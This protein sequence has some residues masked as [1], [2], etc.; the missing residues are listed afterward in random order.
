MESISPQNILGVFTLVKGVY[1]LYPI[2]G[3]RRIQSCTTSPHNK[4]SRK[5]TPF[6]PQTIFQT[7]MKT[8][9]TTKTV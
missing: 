9:A 4:N 7:Q 8:T 3:Q 1:T 6:L 5:L 2:T